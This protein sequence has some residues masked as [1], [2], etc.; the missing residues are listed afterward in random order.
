MG[1]WKALR[2]ARTGRVGSKTVIGIETPTWKRDPAGF[3]CDRGHMQ[4]PTRVSY[5]DNHSGLPEARPCASADAVLLVVTVTD[6]ARSGL[7]INNQQA[8]MRAVTN[9]TVLVSRYLTSRPDR[10]PSLPV[11]TL[12]HPRACAVARRHR[13]LPSGTRTALVIISHHPPA[14]SQ[15]SFSIYLDHNYTNTC[16]S[17]PLYT[18]PLSLSHALGHGTAG[19]LAISP[20]KR[21]ITL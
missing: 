11:H 7:G 8:G 15:S 3:N 12:T 5:T 6:E 2:G 16:P 18:F 17:N 13:H 9:A 21:F 19:L 1:T 14:L 10:V 4:R 20:P